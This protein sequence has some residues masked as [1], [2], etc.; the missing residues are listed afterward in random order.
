MQLYFEEYGK[1]D[2]PILLIL[3]GF[4]ASSRNWR[5]IAQQLSVDYHVYSIDLRNHGQSPHHVDMDYPCMAFDIKQFLEQQQFKKISI[6]GHSMGGK[7]AMYFALHYPNYINQLMIVDISPMSYQH[8]FNNTISA[9]KN[10]NLVGL[11]NRKQALDALAET[12]PELSYRQFLL[13][14]LIL[15]QGNYAWRID[16]DIF[17]E[18]ADNIIAFPQMKDDYTY[19]LPVLFI[20][21]AQS[22]YVQH[23]SVLSL[24]PNASIQTIADAGHWVHA[25]Q[26]AAFCELVKGWL[27]S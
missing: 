17:F 18:S 16:L 14:N 6:L 23:D 26:P 25:A 13:Q 11:T 2:F 21:G 24:F 3:H 9:L 5:Q 12:I 7:I 10:I 15:K 19:Q 22:D 20:K 27:A 1:K 8:S 4:F